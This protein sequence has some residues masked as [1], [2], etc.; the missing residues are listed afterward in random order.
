MDNFENRRARKRKTIDDFGDARHSSIPRTGRTTHRVRVGR[1]WFPGTR[2]EGVTTINPVPGRRLFSEG[3]RPFSGVLGEAGAAAR[4]LET[5][6]RSN[7]RDTGPPKEKITRLPY[8]PA[9]LP[10]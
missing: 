4:H 9:P 7:G 5:F 6:S 10:L 3:P 1:S 8:L 2:T